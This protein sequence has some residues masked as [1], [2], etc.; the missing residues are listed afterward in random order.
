MGF[1]AGIGTGDVEC[2][3]TQNGQTAPFIVVASVR[4]T[5]METR[6]KSA[7][8]AV[9]FASKIGQLAGNHFLTIVEGREHLR[10]LGE[11]VPWQGAQ[12]ILFETL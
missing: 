12:D 8:G 4:Q 7:Y 11:C 3:A 2:E 9:R 6:P 10:A 5:F 1:A